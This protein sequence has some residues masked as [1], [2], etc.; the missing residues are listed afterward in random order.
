[1]P[2]QGTRKLGAIQAFAGSRPV[3]WVDDEFYEDAMVWADGR[4]HPTLLVRPA[5]YVGL[6]E[7]HFA[8]IKQF[9]IS[10]IN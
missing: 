6:T 8:S 1:M 4:A 9:S 2:R 7:E 5:P 10:S 3:A